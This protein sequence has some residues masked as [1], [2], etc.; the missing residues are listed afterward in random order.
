VP[1]NAQQFL[2]AGLPWSKDCSTGKPVIKKSFP[3]ST[4]TQHPVA[5]TDVC[6]STYEDPITG[7]DYCNSWGREPIAWSPTINRTDILASMNLSSDPSELTEVVLP[8]GK[9]VITESVQLP[10]NVVLRGAGANM[11]EVKLVNFGANFT[12]SGVTNSAKAGIENLTILGFGSSN[13]CNDPS[14]GQFAI[15]IINSSNCWI[16]GVVSKLGNGKGH[17]NLTNSSKCEVSGCVVENSSCFTSKSGKGYGIFLAGSNKNLI[18]HNR[19]STLRHH[20]L[21][22]EGSSHNAITH[23]FCEN[24]ICD[25]LNPYGLCGQIEFHGGG[26]IANLIEGNIIDASINYY[27]ESSN[28]KTNNGGQDV[29]HNNIRLTPNNPVVTF[30]AIGTVNLNNPISPPIVS[31]SSTN[32]Y[33]GSNALPTWA[34][35]IPLAFPVANLQQAILGSIVPFKECPLAVDIPLKIVSS[36]VIKANSNFVEVKDC[37]TYQVVSTYFD[38]A[39]IRL[40]LTNGTP[41]YRISSSNPNTTFAT[42][43]SDRL[44]IFF[45][46]GGNYNVKIT[47]SGNKTPVDFN[48]FIPSDFETRWTGYCPDGLVTKANNESVL[49]EKNKDKNKNKFDY[50][51]DGLDF[52]N[53][54]PKESIAASL[55]FTAFPNPMTEQMNIRYNI[56]EADVISL[57]IIN[58]MGQVVRVIE[59]NVPKNTGAYE[60]S[61]DKRELSAGLYYGIF[62]SKNYQHRFKVVIN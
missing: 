19:L 15:N 17:I 10:K 54:K 37:G 45:T 56:Q 58:S 12:I 52:T 46:G 41:P 23:N 48:V 22:E 50:I 1:S 8:A 3:Y 55:Q 43:F 16:K 9:F 21:L 38:Q 32:K 18:T 57:K 53:L 51:P 40:T 31:N 30:G 27:F 60:A 20:I 62:S 11:T 33:Y 42:A 4:I 34:R 14:D 44:L 7:N 5:F 2:E 39:Q 47:D 29:I 35:G 49:R 28:T 6:L 61:F 13:S 24:T 25:N 26:G 36:T 59:D